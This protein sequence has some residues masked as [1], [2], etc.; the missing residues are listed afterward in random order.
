M[1]F[2]YILRNPQGILYK[3]Q[4]NNLQKRI[5]QHNAEDDFASYTKNRGPWTLVYTEE[6]ATR[7][8]ARTREKFLKSGKGREFL[9]SL[10]S[11]KES[12][13]L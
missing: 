5:E 2:V 9:V 10:L 3:G 13:D 4:T 8:D 11:K 1:Y 12:P 6:C 7:S